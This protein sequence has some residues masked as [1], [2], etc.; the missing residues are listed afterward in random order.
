MKKKPRGICDV[1]NDRK[2]NVTLV[3]WKDNKVVT[4]ASTVFEKELIREANHYIKERGG[5][6]ETNQLNAIAVYNKTMGEVDRMGQNISDYMIN[7]RNK[8]WWWPL[9]RFCIDLAVNNAHQLYRLQL[10]QPG[11]R[12]LNLLGFRREIVQ[13]YCSR[14]GNV[15]KI[16]PEICPAPQNHQKVIPDICYGNENHWIIKG[17]QRRCA[18]CSKTSI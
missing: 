11:Q 18:N 7:V 15:K 10:L 17:K 5:K 16:L 13:V 12:A 8:K 14:Y 1:V 6:V 4:A 3:R 2:S 9:F